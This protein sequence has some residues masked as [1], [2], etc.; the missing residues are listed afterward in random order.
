MR[1]FIFLL[2][3]L[4]SMCL[5]IKA[6]TRH[7]FEIVYFS[8]L[9]EFLL[10]KYVVLRLSYKFLIDC[11]EESLMVPY[12]LIGFPLSATFLQKVVVLGVIQRRKNFEL[13]LLHYIDLTQ[14]YLTHCDSKNEQIWATDQKLL[15]FCHYGRVNLSENKLPWPYQITQ[16]LIGPSG[17]LKSQI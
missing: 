3:L 11:K 12:H 6:E 15:V 4:Y 10:S 17:G 16:P 9:S 5:F 1:V 7:H 13:E 2:R 8:R 14:K